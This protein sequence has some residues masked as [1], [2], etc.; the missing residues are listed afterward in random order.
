MSLVIQALYIHSDIF[1][2]MVRYIDTFSTI[3]LVLALFP[4]AAWIAVSRAQHNGLKD[5]LLR[6][7]VLSARTALM[8]PSYA[9]LIWI[10]LF[11]PRS[12]Y[13]MAFPIAIAEGETYLHINTVLPRIKCH[14]SQGSPSTHFSLW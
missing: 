1:A 14:I 10:T 7:Q 5:G 3:G 2:V 8:L 4:I 9:I 11:E 12:S 6:L 13:I